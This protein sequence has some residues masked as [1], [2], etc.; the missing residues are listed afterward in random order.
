M[1][2]PSAG[3]PA[4]YAYAAAVLLEQ[5][6][7]RDREQL[8]TVV[9]DVGG[10]HP[11]GANAPVNKLMSYIKELSSLLSANY[12]ERVKR[13][14]IFPVP[15]VVRG[16][17]SAVKL[18]LDPVT[19]EKA[20]LLSGGDPKKGIRYPAE[21]GKYIDMSSLK[22]GPLYGLPHPKDVGHPWRTN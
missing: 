4:Q 11:D 7:S 8:M 17:W 6:F 3:T 13:I 19:A 22:P 9:V 12:P 1:C 18:F 15:L 21:L 5:N 10:V 16:I 20:V 14:V 2:D